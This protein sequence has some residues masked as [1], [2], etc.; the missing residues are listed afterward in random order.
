MSPSLAIYGNDI[1]R[2]KRTI[3]T[4]H[5]KPATAGMSLVIRIYGNGAADIKLCEEQQQ[6]CN[7]ADDD[8]GG[9]SSGGVAE[10]LRGGSD[11]ALLTLTLGAGRR[12]A[13]K[14]R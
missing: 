5:F 2:L 7:M 9:G 3:T 14:D 12:W 1:T 13:V 6:R 10:T 11:I 8:A 4:E